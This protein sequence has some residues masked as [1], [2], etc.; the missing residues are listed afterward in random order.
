MHTNLRNASSAFYGRL[1]IPQNIRSSCCTI[2]RRWWVNRS[3]GR[4]E[5]QAW[6]PCSFQGARWVLGKSALSKESFNSRYT[7]QQ[8]GNPEKHPR[9]STAACRCL[10]KYTLFVLFGA[11]PRISWTLRT[12][13]RQSWMLFSFQLATVTSL[14]SCFATTSCNS[15]LCAPLR[16]MYSPCSN[17]GTVLTPN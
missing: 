17:A 12:T 9:A 6:L 4:T 2:L 10:K 7:C 11:D 5:E 1:S 16:K 13:L 3:L 14:L 15:A 8:T